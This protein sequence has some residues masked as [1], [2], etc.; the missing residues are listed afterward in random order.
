M[1][2]APL[3]AR[4]CLSLDDEDGDTWA[5]A[6]EFARGSDRHAFALAVEPSGC[7]EAVELAVAAPEE[8]AEMLELTRRDAAGQGFAVTEVELDQAEFRWR[9]EAAL[10]A[11]GVHDAESG[12]AGS[13]GDPG[14][15]GWPSDLLDDDGPAYHALEPIFRARLRSLPRPNK[16]KP[17]HGPNTGGLPAFDPDLLALAAR[18]FADSGRPR[19]LPPKPARRRGTAPI[20]RLRVDLRDAKPPIWRRLEVP[21]DITL[22]RLHE[23]LQTAFGWDGGHLHVFETDYGDFG[24]PDSDLGH[25]SDQRATLEQVAGPGRKLT[26]LYDFG[27]DWRHVIA[28]EAEAPREAGIRYPRCTGGRR[29]GPPDDCGGIWGYQY[30][31]GV[32]AD[33]AHQEHAERL[34]WLGI[35]DASQFDPAAFDRDLVNERLVPAARRAASPRSGR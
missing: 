26:Y 7:R 3:A 30:L 19:T 33:P 34:D 11:R 35:T 29:A 18:W 9:A 12:L 32:L 8:I 22:A 20:F 27:D 1:F 17:V 2:D 5:L 6:C 31:L 10:D 16:P 4:R 21:A 23:V 28:V 13:A 15:R 14:A 24:S 25:R